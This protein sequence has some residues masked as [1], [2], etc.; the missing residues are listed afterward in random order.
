MLTGALVHN[1][2]R[3]LLGCLVDEGNPCITRPKA[4]VF[5]EKG[6]RQ[7]ITLNWLCINREMLLPLLK[8]AIGAA[9]AGYGVRQVGEGYWIALQDLKSDRADDVVK[10]V[11][12]QKSD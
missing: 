5:E 11:E 4:C 3:P 1:K 9:A 7:T 2:S 10:A 8:K 6:Q 12:D